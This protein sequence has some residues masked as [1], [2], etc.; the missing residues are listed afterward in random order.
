MNQKTK[1]FLTQKKCV[2]GQSPDTQSTTW[3]KFQ[4]VGFFI[5]PAIKNKKSY[6]LFF[7]H[8][9]VMLLRG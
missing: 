6:S 2:S 8:D 7:S 9:D 1:G 4:V 5:Q 3:K